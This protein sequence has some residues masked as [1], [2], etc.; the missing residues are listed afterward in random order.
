MS[1]AKDVTATFSTPSVSLG[2]ALDY[3]GLVWNTGG[4]APFT[5]QTAN[6][7]YGGSAAQ[8]GRVGN[9]QRS[10]LSTTV[11]GPGTL[12]FYWRVS[13]STGNSTFS[14]SLD[15]VAKS[16]RIGNS[17]WSRSELIIPTGIHTVSWEYR[18]DSAYAAVIRD[19]ESVEDS[20]SASG[21][22][23]GWI[24]YVVF[25]ASTPSCTYALS[26]D[27]AF[28][29][30]QGAIG[31]VT[32]NTA[33]HCNWTAV[34]SAPW[35]TVNSGS[36][37]VGN[38]DVLFT[39][40][41]NT[42]TQRTG[43]I[44]VGDK[45]L[46]ITQSGANTTLY[47]PHVDTTF[48]WQ[49]EIAIINTSLDQSVTGF[50]KGLSNEGQLVEAKTVTLSARGRRQI[51]VSSEFANH[52]NIGYMIF[53]TDAASVQGYTKFYQEGTDRVAIPA[54]T[55][56]NASDIYISHIA[57]NEQWWTGVSLVN[58]T[59]TPKELTITFNNGLSVPYTLNGKEHRAFTIRHLF[60]DQ[61]Q[62]DIRSA[63]ITNASGV[64]G[65]ELFGSLGWGAQLEGIPL[66]D[67]TAST[68]YYPHVASDGWWTGIVAY[69]PSDT[70]CTITVSPYTAQG[71]P[72][73]PSTIPIAGKGKY[74]GTVTDLGLPAQAAWFRIDSTRPL[75]GFELF[76]TTDGNQLAAYAAGGAAGAKKGVFAKIEKN[77]WTGIAFVNT[78]ASAASV[79]LTAFNDS[80]AAVATRILPVSG[81]AK[82]VNLPE[83]IFTQDVS[84][85]TYITYLSDRNLMGFQINGA[86]ED[87]LLDG[88]TS[89]GMMLDGLP[90]LAGTN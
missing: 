24:D 29:S 62:P 2:A 12:S 6:A 58:T 72:L 41:A 57:S 22:D 70:A 69:N 83:R 37:G 11:V 89:T 78:E 63:V 90:A 47:F 87:M 43:T 10:Y 33:P 84:D 38:G 46:T 13:S 44:T 9:Q 50:L 67:N 53:E 79:T 30:A 18:K 5:P 61:P 21:D 49:T 85:A 88:G 81:H 34:S 82:V 1:A 80:G 77:G 86:S 8:A 31:A 59:P 55:K 68:I 76:G 40:T 51:T 25:T 19:Q 15:G 36:T 39:V 73:S 32:M 16:S 20:S 28:Y 26:A 74:I 66:T 71:D 48:P 4:D 23:A 14:V 3:T 60:N 17:P 65:L 64:I 27:S 45:T 54:A 56:V 35:I 75:S 52:T 7:Y 42:E